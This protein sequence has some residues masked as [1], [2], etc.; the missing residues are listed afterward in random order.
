[1]T[2]FQQTPTCD[3]TKS[4]PVTTM[5]VPV[6]QE[7]F[8]YRLSTRQ[9]LLRSENLTY[10]VDYLFRGGSEPLPD[11]CDADINGDGSVNVADLTYLVD[12]LFRGG[13]A[14]VDDCCS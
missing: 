8:V 6:C 1:M 5:S 4:L 14:P 3:S 7:T 10:L 11:L 9:P 13:E 12:Y 2:P